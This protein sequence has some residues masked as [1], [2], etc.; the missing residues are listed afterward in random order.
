MVRSF[1]LV[2][3][4]VFW[5]C[6]GHGKLNL[7]PSVL[8]ET[9]P[10]GT[11]VFLDIVKPENRSGVQLLVVVDGQGDESEVKHVDIYLGGHLVDRLR[12]FEPVHPMNGT[13][14]EYEPQ[15]LR[16]KCAISENQ[17]R[18]LLSREEAMVVI[19][20]DD[21]VAAMLS[22]K[23]LTH[24]ASELSGDSQAP[25]TKVKRPGRTD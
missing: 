13:V 20:A 25:A 15:L 3:T 17:L 18:A 23:N 4:L 12:C 1:V 11:L 6:G 16:S 5:G 22:K 24:L 7:G 14:F 19:G 9:I 2:F 8:H 10:S 21:P